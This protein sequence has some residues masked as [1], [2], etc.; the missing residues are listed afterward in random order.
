[1]SPPTPSPT[2]P[3]WSVLLGGGGGG[4][5]IQLLTSAVQAG[6][7]LITE[8]TW[9]KRCWLHVWPPLMRLFSCIRSSCPQTIQVFLNILQL[10]LKLGRKR[11]KRLRGT[12]RVKEDI[13][14]GK[15]KTSQSI[16]PVIPLISETFPP[17]SSV[18]PFL[19]PW[20]LPW[21]FSSCWL[22][23]P[24][25]CLAHPRI[26]S[27]RK[28]CPTFLSTKERW[29]NNHVLFT[30]ACSSERI[31]LNFYGA[32]ESIS[33]AHIAWR[34]GGRICK[35]LRSPGIDSKESIPPGWE[36][37][38]GL[39]K[40]FTNS[41]SVRQ[42]FSYSVPIAPID[43]SKTPA[44]LQN[45]LQTLTKAEIWNIHI[46]IWQAKRAPDFDVHEAL[47]RDMYICSVFSLH[48]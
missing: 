40:R 2:P 7:E 17:P 42:P 30:Y 19:S 10:K 18:P 33:P 21:P 12:W 15:R 32:Q 24:L 1:M 46:L 22:F 31:F 44:L 11:Q 35:S 47:T 5:I 37:T 29:T 38:N 4:A 48:N 14:Y 27:N 3:T 16:P 39:I 43:C 8:I 9:T 45:H 23:L 36:S 6:F 26:F 13:W 25:L 34:A 20:N 41:G 28:L